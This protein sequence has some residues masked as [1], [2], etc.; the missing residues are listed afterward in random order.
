VEP[1]PVF[2]NMSSNPDLLASPTD[3][4]VKAQIEPSK[5]NFRP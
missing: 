1:C 4:P 2:L 5:E 3:P